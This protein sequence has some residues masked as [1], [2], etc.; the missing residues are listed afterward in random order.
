LR[1]VRERRFTEELVG[2]VYIHQNLMAALSETGYFNSALQDLVD[3]C[4]G[5]VLI[6]DDVTFPILR[7][8]GERQVI[9]GIFKR[10]VGLRCCSNGFHVGLQILY[11]EVAMAGPE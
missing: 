3:A 8:V 2:L 4:R 10:R 6:V 7:D 1:K 11:L 5:C 9:Q